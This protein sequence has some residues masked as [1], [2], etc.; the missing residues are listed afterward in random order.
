MLEQRRQHLI[1]LA[2][3]LGAFVP[4]DE[5]LLLAEVGPAGQL[6]D[7]ALGE[8]GID[9]S[10]AYVTNAVKHFKFEPR[11][12]IRLH[13]KPNAG[14]I[15]ACRWWLARELSLIEPKLIVALG[16]TALQSLVGRALPITASEQDCTIAASSRSDRTRSYATAPSASEASDVE[17]R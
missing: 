10:I 17:A 6:F 14:E 7:R 11:G 1:E 2:E 16:A 13:K 3:V 5:A 12:K 4:V 15:D 9:R 8:A